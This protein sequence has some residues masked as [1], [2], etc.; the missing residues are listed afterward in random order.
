MTVCASWG[1]SSSSTCVFRVV[2]ILTHMRHRYDS[3]GLGGKVYVHCAYG[4]HRG[5][6]MGS[7]VLIAQGYE[8]EVA[9]KLVMERRRVANP[10][11]YYIRSRILKFAREWERAKSATEIAAS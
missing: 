5:P 11:I 4:R 2:P 3:C 9:M 6:A 7:C 1:Y 10:H 8:P